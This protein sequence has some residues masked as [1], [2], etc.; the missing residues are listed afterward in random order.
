MTA[1]STLIP[2]HPTLATRQPETFVSFDLPQAS[3]TGFNRQNA[4]ARF[5]VLP[6]E[7]AVH[8]CHRVARSDLFWRNQRTRRESARPLAAHGSPL[9]FQPRRNPD[10]TGPCA[11]SPVP[12]RV[13]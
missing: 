11:G 2:R 13:L 5:R 8:L 6:F 9:S 1:D 7:T 4:T 10:K 3:T 12:L